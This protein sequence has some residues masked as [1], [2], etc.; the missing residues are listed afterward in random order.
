MRL[1]K[2]TFLLF[3]FILTFALAYLF[4]FDTFAAILNTKADVKPRSVSTHQML[5]R[6]ITSKNAPEPIVEEIEIEEEETAP[7]TLAF[8]GDILLDRSVGTRIEQFGVDYPFSKVSRLLREVDIAAGN[9]ETSVSL[10]GAPI[11]DKQFTFRSNPKT[12]QGLVNAGF[13]MVSLA[14]NHT[15]DFGTIALLDTINYL[16]D[17]KIG[18]SGAGINEAEAFQAYT[19][20]VNG[21]KI[22]IIGLSRVLPH[23][24]WYATEKRPGIAHAYI[25]EPMLSYV[26]NAVASADYTFVMIHWNNEKKDFPEDYARDLAREF[27]HAGVTAVIGSH[28]HTLMGVEFIDDMPVYY[29][30]GNFVF[31]DSLDPKG[32]ES[33]VVTITLEDDQLT[34]KITPVEI[35]QSQPNLMDVNYKQKIINKIT[36]L[37]YNAKVQQDG[38]VI[39]TIKK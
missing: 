13:D 10:R 28:S 29:S 18:F 11:P 19:K 38:T 9:L 20:E 14:N 39:Q 31:T 6:E 8:T 37:S 22:A 23:T 3:T 21:K 27:A 36:S 25:L 12:L 17:Y 35:I 24:D 7:I 2:I 30:L 4:F 34:S 1:I 15:L 33:M 16:K 26:K 32:R 5:G